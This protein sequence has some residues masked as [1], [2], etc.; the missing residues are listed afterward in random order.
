MANRIFDDHGPESEVAYSCCWAA[1]L[2]MK[3]SLQRESST[4]RRSL[5]EGSTRDAEPVS[6][7]LLARPTSSSR[8]AYRDHEA[9]RENSTM[10]S[11]PPESADRRERETVGQAAA[12]PSCQ[13]LAGCL[14]SVHQTRSS[15]PRGPPEVRARQ[16]APHQSPRVAVLLRPAG[17]PPDSRLAK[18]RECCGKATVTGAR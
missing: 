18:K 16:C 11:T 13:R 10:R 3:A 14:R 6:L 15:D 7:F 1:L 4:H 12:T 9:L 2:A 17:L 5:G 8:A